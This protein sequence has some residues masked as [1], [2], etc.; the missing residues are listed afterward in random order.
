MENGDL[1]DHGNPFNWRVVELKQ[2]DIYKWNILP[3]LVIQFIN[4]IMM[5]Y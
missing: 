1:I 2:W 5:R 3:T 4:I